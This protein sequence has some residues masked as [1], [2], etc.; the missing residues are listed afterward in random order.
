MDPITINRIAQIRQQEILEQAA[1]DQGAPVLRRLG[2]LLV[3]IGQK[4]MQ[5]N[6]Y[7]ARAAADGNRSHAALDNEVCAWK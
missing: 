7:E 4:M 1:N 6:G 5:T 3:T 2:S